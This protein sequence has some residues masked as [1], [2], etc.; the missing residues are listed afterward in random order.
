M[1]VGQ[2][3]D[4]LVGYRFLVE[5]DALVV[6]GFSGVSGLGM[7]LETEDYQEGGLNTH[8]HAL[9]TRASYEPVTLERGLTESTVLWDWARSGRNGHPERKTVRVFLQDTTGAPTWGW[10]LEGAYPVGWTGPELRADQAAI[11][12]E[13]LELA[14]TGLSKIPGLP[15]PGGAI[16]ELL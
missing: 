4:P 10:A 11:A 5:V 16:R 15:P 1:S 6:A 14:H 7:T 12:V 3:T 2:R 13:A 8:A 9:P